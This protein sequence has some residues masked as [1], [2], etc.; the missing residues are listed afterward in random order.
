[1]SDSTPAGGPPIE[2]LTATFLVVCPQCEARA[3]VEDRGSTVCL[4]CAGCGRNEE[5]PATTTRILGVALDAYFRLPLWLSTDCCEKTLWAYNERHLEWL[6]DFLGARLAGREPDARWGW[7]NMA[8]GG[9]VSR[10]MVD[11]ANRA[12][13]EQG[14]ERLRA[15]LTG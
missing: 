3:V 9:R 2:D 14:F 1:M 7:A 12:E 8:L 5:K 11:P 10:W 13:I 6:E 4:I 15:R